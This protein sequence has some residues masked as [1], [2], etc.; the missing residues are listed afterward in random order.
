MHLSSAASF[1]FGLLLTSSTCLASEGFLPGKRAPAVVTPPIL[2]PT[3][4][5]PASCTSTVKGTLKGPSCYTRTATTT[6]SAGCP[7]L[8][9]PNLDL[10]CPALIKVT[11]TEIPCS[12]DCCPKTPTKYITTSCAGCATGCVI[13]T[14]TVTVTTGCKIT[15]F[16]TVIQPTATLIFTA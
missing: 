2:T 14:E 11:T 9:C 6:P 13:P 5:L 16:P 3:V 8:N 15:G 4:N 7:K 1:L 10:V 12:T